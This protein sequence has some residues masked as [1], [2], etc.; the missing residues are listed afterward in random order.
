MK[1][2]GERILKT[3]C[4]YVAERKDARER[5]KTGGF[6]IGGAHGSARVM[7]PQRTRR[8]E[9]D[10][11]WFRITKENITGEIKKNYSLVSSLISLILS[12]SILN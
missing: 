4:F 10:L 11:K 5:R 3:G 2:T 8:V 7:Q 6:Y 9:W 12:I 1:K